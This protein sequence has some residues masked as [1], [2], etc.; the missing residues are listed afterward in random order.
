MRYLPIPPG[1]LHDLLL[2]IDPGQKGFLVYDLD[3]I[4]SP[5]PI[6]RGWYRNHRQAFRA[7]AR[8]PIGSAYVATVTQVAP[9][10]WFQV[11]K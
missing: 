4:I 8:I 11:A 9:E 1:D 5:K 3:L 7:A 6:L 2:E 10:V